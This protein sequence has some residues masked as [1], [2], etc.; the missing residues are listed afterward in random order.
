MVK[1]DINDNIIGEP[2]TELLI[3]IPL[4]LVSFFGLWVK[5]QDKIF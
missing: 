3:V 1:C 4:Q 2:L 5:L